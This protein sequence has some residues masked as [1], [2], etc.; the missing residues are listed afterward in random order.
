MLWSLRPSLLDWRCFQAS[1]PVACLPRYREVP[2]PLAGSHCRHNE[3]WMEECC[4][5]PR[6]L[7]SG[8]CCFPVR[9]ENAETPPGSGPLYWSQAA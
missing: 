9:Q 8:W 4:F 6:G 2:V 7:L 1:A 5:L 3:D